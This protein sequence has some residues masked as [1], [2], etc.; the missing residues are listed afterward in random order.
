M[1]WMKSATATVITALAE[2]FDN[3]R[4]VLGNE[5]ERSILAALN[6]ILFASGITGVALIMWAF[7]G[8]A[9]MYHRKHNK[10]FDPLLI[11]LLMANLFAIVICCS[12]LIYENVSESCPRLVESHKAVTSLDYTLLA[13]RRILMLGVALR[14]TSGDHLVGVVDDGY[15]DSTVSVVSNVCS[16]LIVDHNH[17][18]I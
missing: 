6:L 3:L 17:E 10:V 9:E 11:N 12:L 5:N 7:W 18:G 2:A 4:Q 15:V 13:S 14:A 8:I 1:E 16:Q